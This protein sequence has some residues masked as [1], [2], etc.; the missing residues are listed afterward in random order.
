MRR[1]YVV[2][3]FLMFNLFMIANAQDEV[4][5]HSEEMTYLTDAIEELQKQNE[6]QKIIIKE[7]HRLIKVQQLRLDGLTSQENSVNKSIVTNVKGE[8]VIFEPRSNPASD[9]VAVNLFIPKVIGNAYI[10]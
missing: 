3:L 5:N 4:T 9:F 8:N 6:A 1:K 2:L 10:K 7:L